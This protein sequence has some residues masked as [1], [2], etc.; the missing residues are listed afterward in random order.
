M[1]RSGSVVTVRKNGR[2]ITSTPFSIGSAS[3]QGPPFILARA[4]D[5]IVCS[6]SGMTLNDICLVT[7]YYRETLWSAT[8][9][10]EVV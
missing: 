1:P 3:A 6:W 2:F 7:W 8:P 10:A 9:G 5:Q 4:G